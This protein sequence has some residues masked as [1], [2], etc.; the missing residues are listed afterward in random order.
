MEVLAL[1]PPEAALGELM[2]RRTTWGAAPLTEETRGM[3]GAP[4]LAA[5]KPTAVLNQRRPGAGG[6]G[7]GAH[8]PCASGA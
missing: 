4:E 6:G 2:A 8:A 5:M 1:R 3:I 7:G